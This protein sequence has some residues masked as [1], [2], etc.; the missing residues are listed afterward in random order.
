MSEIRWA[1]LRWYADLAA[2][3]YSSKDKIHAIYDKDFSVYINEINE[4]QYIVLTDKDYQLN[5]TSF[6][7]PQ[8]TYP[9]AKNSAGS[10][11]VI[12]SGFNASLALRVY[13]DMNLYNT[14]TF[15]DGSWNS[16]GSIYGSS[17]VVNIVAATATTTFTKYAGYSQQFLY[18]MERD[19]NKKKWL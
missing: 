10:P 1:D 14:L 12:N 8:K 5:N 3:V 2:N 11:I 18:K 15:T 19:L 7:F 9:V 6:K 16:Q 4:I 13:Y 17:S